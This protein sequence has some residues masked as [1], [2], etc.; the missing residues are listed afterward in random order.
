MTP[1]EMYDRLKPIQERQ[2][3]YFNPDYEWCLDV[4]TGM[5]ANK[6]RYGYTSCPC[7][8]ASGE[9]ERDQA[10]ICPCAFREKD[11]QIYN[12]CYCKLYLSQAGAAA[13]SAL[14]E[15]IPDRYLRK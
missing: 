12:M 11:V 4:I 13:P 1:Q 15:T 10:I 3:Y 5:L 7:R 9:R 14:P 2:G 6:E 8:L